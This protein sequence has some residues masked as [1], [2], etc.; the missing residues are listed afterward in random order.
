MRK[1]EFKID[2]KD[3]TLEMNRDAIVWLEN[4]GFKIT[5]IEDK[6]VTSCALLWASLFVKNHGDISIDEVAKLMDTYSTGGNSVSEIIKF[7]IEEYNTFINALTGTNS[8]KKDESIKITE[9]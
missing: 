6:P 5:D 2:G 4:R 7:G 9:V 1:L 8:K 3:Y